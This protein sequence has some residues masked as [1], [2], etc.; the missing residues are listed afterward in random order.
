MDFNLPQPSPPFFNSPACKEGTIATKIVTNT[1]RPP[2]QQSRKL[3]NYLNEHL[4][5][6]MAPDGFGKILLCGREN[7]AGL[8]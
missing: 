4:Q 6:E 8:A 7:F 5:R 3:R 1:A 2:K